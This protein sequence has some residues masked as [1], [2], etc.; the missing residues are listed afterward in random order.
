MI[1][2]LIFQLDGDGEAESK[3]S[4]R[5]TTARRKPPKI[6]EAAK[7]VKDAA[8]ASKKAE[9]IIVDGQNDDVRLIF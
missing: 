2:W 7:E 1:D 4:M 8:P 6:K 3:R 5:P 9:G